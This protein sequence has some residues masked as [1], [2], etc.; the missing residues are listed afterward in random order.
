M[1]KTS[2]L[3]L[4][5]GGKSD[6]MGF[7]KGLL[8]FNGCYWI[9]EQISRF[10]HISEPK[11]YI[12]LGFDYDTYIAHIPW[13]KKALTDPY[14]FDGVE[15]KVVLNKRPELGAFSTLQAVLNTVETGTSIIVQPIDVPLLNSRELQ[16]LLTLENDIV[17]PSYKSKNGHPVKLSSK[18]W[19]PLL[20][21]NSTNEKA[22]LDTQIKEI[23][24]GLISYCE[25]LDDAVVEN[26]NNE[27][28]WKKYLEKKSSAN[29]RS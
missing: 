27:V 19:M 5:A 7:P 22:R 21:I 13:L 29:S 6:R 15:V 20:K 25:V 17:I 4:L 16:K 9:L 14:I 11:V 24:N 1:V 26:L 10:R 8:D 18:F 12:G 28:A 23:K 3:V 2:I